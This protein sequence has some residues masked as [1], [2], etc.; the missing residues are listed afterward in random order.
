MTTGDLSNGIFAQSIGG[1]GGDGGFAIAGSGTIGLAENT[2][3]GGDAAGGNDGGTVTVVNAGEIETKGEGSDAVLAQSVGGGGGDGG[4][5]IAGSVTLNRGTVFSFG[6]DGAAGGNGGNVNLGNT[7]AT[8]V[9]RGANSNGLEAQSLGGGGGNGGFAIAGGITAKGTVNIGFGGA[10]STGGNAGTVALESGDATP[11]TIRTFG[12]NSNGMLAQSVGG[13]GGNGGFAIGG[14]ISGGVTIDESFGGNGAT[15]GDGG[16]IRLTNNSTIGTAGTS[17]NAIAAQSLGGGGGAGGFSIAGSLSGDNNVSLGLGG[18]GGTGGRGG[19]VTVDNTSPML[20]T[21]GD[22]SN[23]ILAQGIGGG[24]GAGGFS[25]SGSGSLGTQ[26][27]GMSLGGDGGSGGVGGEPNVQ[28]G[29]AN[30]T[31]AIMT[32]GAQSDGILEQSIGGGGGSGGFS[33]EGLA[34]EGTVLGLSVGG[35]GGKGNN[36]GGSD[37]GTKLLNFSNITTTG[38]SSNGILV[39]SIGGGGGSAGF[40]VTANVAADSNG[41]S[42]AGGFGFGSGGS[43]GNGEVANVTNNGMIATTGDNANGVVAQSIGGGGGYGGFSFATQLRGDLDVNEGATNSGGGSGGRVELNNTGIVVTSG[44]NAGDLVAQS[45]G[46]GGGDAGFAIAG[47]VANSGPSTGGVDLTLG[48]NGGAGGNGGGVEVLSTGIGLATRGTNSDGILAQSIG[49]GGGNGGFAIAA[50]VSTSYG[51]GMTLGGAGGAGGSGG[52]VDVGNSAIVLTRGAFSDGIAAQ[53]IGGG[54]GNGGFAIDG[55]VSFGVQGNMVFGGSAGRGSDGGAVTV[56]NAGPILTQGVGSDGILGESI[57]GG[58]GNGGFSIAATVAQG[59]TTALSFGGSGGDNGSGGNVTIGNA[60]PAIVTRG[61]DSAAIAA[62]SVGGGGGSGA[63]AIDGAL[64]GG[65]VMSLGGNGGAGGN[66]GK[67]LVL[68]GSATN[69]NTALGTS[70]FNAAGIL[71]QSIGGGGGN[72]GLGIGGP[73]ATTPLIGLGV[74]GSGGG[75]G[76][77]GGVTVLN[78]G[79]IATLGAFSDDILAQS[80]GGGGGAGNVNVTGATNTHVDGPVHVGDTLG[81]GGNGGLTEVGNANQLTTTGSAASGIVAQSIGDGGGV[82]GYADAV[83]LNSSDGGGLAIGSAGG[84]CGANIDVAR[85]PCGGG[86]GGGVAVANTGVIVTAGAASGG[87]SGQSVGGGGGAGTLLVGGDYSGKGAFGI[88]LGGLNAQGNGGAVAAVNT[89]TGGIG[90]NGFHAGGLQLQSVGGGGGSGTIVIGGNIDSAS[91]LTY[92]AGATETIAGTSA[93]NGGN[94]TGNNAA[95]VV[96]MGDASAGLAA[97][98]IGGGGG[99][100]AIAIAGAVAPGTA[101]VTALIGG[102]NVAGGNGGTVGVTNSGTIGTAGQGSS[103]LLAQSIGGGGGTGGFNGTVNATLA[104]DAFALVVAGGNADVESNA[105]AVTATNSGA[106]VTIGAG[107]AG[108][109][110]QSVGGGGGNSDLSMNLALGT[111]GAANLAVG[112]GGTNAYHSTGGD[113]GVTNGAAITT[114]GYD[115]LGLTAQSIGGG[116]GN[117]GFVASGTLTT[118]TSTPQLIVD[119]G[120]NGGVSDNAGA[121]TVN[122]TAAV[123]TFGD[124]SPAIV[125]QSIGGGG[126]NSDLAFIGAYSGGTP[127]DA[128]AFVGGTG[129]VSGNGSKVTVNNTGDVMTGAVTDGATT[130]AFAGGILAQSIGGGGGTGGLA[131]GLNVPSGTPATGIVGERLGGSAGIG[132]GAT[133]SAGSGGTVSLSDSGAVQTAGGGA[134]GLEA[135]SIGGGGGN[136]NVDVFG[137]ATVGA[138]GQVPSTFGLAT[139]VGGGSGVANIGG[140]VTLSHD[141]GAVATFGDGSDALLAQSIGGGGGDGGSAHSISGAPGT[142]STSSATCSAQ[143][144]GL[145][146]EAGG[147]G[148]GQSNNGGAVSVSNDGMIQT[149]GEDASAIVAQSIGGGGGLAGDDHSPA[150]SNLQVWDVLVGGRNKSAGSGGNVTVNDG[151]GILTMGDGSHGI[152]AQSVGGG[153][154]EAG[155]GVAGGTGSIALGGTSGANGNGGNV[156]VTISS[157]KIETQGNGAFGILA[158]SVGGGGGIAG[159]LDFGISKTTVG[160]GSTLTASGGGGGNGG[161]VTVNVTG[162]IETTGSGSDGIFAQSVGGGGGLAGA[163]ASTGQSFAG[164]AGA[165][166]KGGT[167]NVTQTGIIATTGN[168]S[169][170]IFAQSAGG[171]GKGGDVNV[172][173]QGEALAYG[174]NADGVFA[175]SSGGAGS[176]N[177]HVT[178]AAGSVVQGGT[179]GGSVGVRLVGTGTNTLTNNGTITTAATPVAFPFDAARR[180]TGGVRA[181]ATRVQI[182][183]TM[184]P[185]ASMQLQGLMTDRNFATGGQV[186][187]LAVGGTL[188]LANYGSIFGSIALDGAKLDLVNYG[189]MVTGANLNLAQTGTLTMAMGSAMTPGGGGFIAHTDAIGN[190]MQQAGSSYLV[191]LDLAHNNASSFNVSGTANVGGT[192]ALDLLNTGAPSQGSHSANILSAAGGVTNAGMTLAPPNTAVATFSL[193]F[194]PNDVQLNYNVDYAPRRGGVLDVNDLALGGYL[195]RI[196][197]S[198]TASFQPMMQT[199]FAIPTLTNL[200]SFYDHLVPSGSMALSSSALLSNLDFS[201]QMFGCGDNAKSGFLAANNCN[202]GSLGAAG[203]EQ[204][205]TFGSVGYSQQSSGFSTGYQR[206]IG[207]GGNTSFGAAFRYGNGSLSADDGGFSYAGDGLAAG[208]ML[209]RVGS[210]GTAF[211]ASLVGG[212]STYASTRPIGY[213]APTTVAT[214]NQS[215]WYAGAHLRAERTMYQ[216][217]TTSIVP[218]VDLGATQ[219]STGALN[220]TG[221]GMLDATVAAQGQLFPT[222]QSGIAFQTTRQLGADTLHAGLGLSVLQIVGNTQTSTTATLAGDP[223]SPFGIS[224]TI[225]RTYFDIGPSLE[226][227]SSNKLDIRLGGAYDFSALSHALGGSVQF[228]M[229]L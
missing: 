25:I 170:A 27:I 43:G 153:G 2:S 22:L 211:S 95:V 36:A 144:T 206:A 168:G 88:A 120:A 110:A 94:V 141:G 132:G 31:T 11:T 42:V 56:A 50:D 179:G 161:N 6:G 103:A 10:A 92:R 199:V 197:Q 15:G 5:S 55:T 81:L 61:D 69:P 184:A 150:G 96:T 207:S 159:N 115:S 51:T 106:L 40:N 129:N 140:S 172:T 165:L 224:S 162:N 218:F 152:V 16:T 227:S 118:G 169:D 143:M 209:K 76:N 178:V 194:D 126:G 183:G 123:Q 147:D 134:I 125:A 30:T 173:V 201:S 37:V 195:G 28:S 77:G 191:T 121:V 79:A 66:G 229:K 117:T 176:G 32:S 215:V 75:A 226:L 63:F 119:V 23:G 149:S 216:T 91:A 198:G 156:N 174:A 38:A 223:T 44:D 171:T 84:A 167:V 82:A 60:S 158:Q 83:N 58:G 154:G 26:A 160:S 136:A 114:A 7:A 72:G 133:S 142:C 127:R 89:V 166:G 18:G 80:V 210:G 53:S 180:S 74:G 29:A 177:I 225:G 221:A 67:V 54:G 203:I 113:V 108:L 228:V 205:S 204:S 164:S 9:T 21:T 213:P 193:G 157:G 122:N 137:T 202:W 70:G 35:S 19:N 98:S 87:A 65:L 33:V 59:T 78:F 20:A 17:S 189:T 57:G 14:G 190:L 175:G 135:Q 104:D 13:G 24:G 85:Q 34:S 41:F 64:S 68:N 196:V 187:V 3:F 101:S 124:G 107:S 105:G 188:K 45:I 181:D 93:N 212:G 48:N 146:A 90:T 112:A 185:A 111:S 138:N 4:F 46:G 131:I 208:V 102:A 109:T 145:F 47:N 148:G 73:T 8:I 151:G 116:G 186:A 52:T 219:V 62:T 139:V 12:E 128:V 49:G 97:Q 200:K 99:D 130:G 214:G 1:G 155:A 71:A 220:E 86:N 217:G 100:G 163:L 182:Q 222:V 39:Q 192:V